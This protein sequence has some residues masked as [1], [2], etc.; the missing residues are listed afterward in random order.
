MK[1]I[2][3]EVKLGFPESDSEEED[4]AADTQINYGTARTQRK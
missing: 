4:D 1:R 2:V 3:P